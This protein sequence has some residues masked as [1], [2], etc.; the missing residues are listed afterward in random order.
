MA[1]EEGEVLRQIEKH[2][3]DLLA[4]QR[5]LE[6]EK[7]SKALQAELG[8][9][10]RRAVWERCDGT[11]TG[12]EIG[13]EVGVSTQRVSQILT[14]LAEKG[15]VSRATASSPYERRLGN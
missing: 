4:L 8:D 11:R 3:G 6:G 12:A 2:L 14:S 7:I 1:D 10:T 5:L 15:L 13:K 9:G